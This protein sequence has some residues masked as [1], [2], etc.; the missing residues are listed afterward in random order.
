MT[1]EEPITL[2]IRPRLPEEQEEKFRAT[3]RR[4]AETYALLEKASAELDEDD[5]SG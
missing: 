1:D 3:D 2:P 4:T 5:D